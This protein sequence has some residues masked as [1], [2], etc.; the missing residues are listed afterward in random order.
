MCI[1]TKYQP[2]FCHLTTSGWLPVKGREYT[3]IQWAMA[4]I[5][6]LEGVI[7]RLEGEKK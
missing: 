5:T 4:E 1:S 6:R 2:P 7:D 3:V